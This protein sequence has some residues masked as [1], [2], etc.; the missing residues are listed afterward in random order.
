MDRDDELAVLAA[1]A[2]EV[3][4][5]VAR[6]VQPGALRGVTL[7]GVTAPPATSPSAGERRLW[8]F[9]DGLWRR[10]VAPTSSTSRWAPDLVPDHRGPRRPALRPGLAPVVG[11][12]Q[13][14]GPLLHPAR[15]PEFAD[16]FAGLAA[17]DVVANNADRK[18]GHVLYDGARCWAIDNGLCFHDAGQAAHRRL[19]VRR[20]S[21]SRPGP[22]RAPRRASREGDGARVARWLDPHEVAL[23]ARA[24]PGALCA[25]S[26]Y[27]T[28]DEDSRLAAVARGRWSERRAAPS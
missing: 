25:A 9:P 23:T 14:R 26:E 27:P 28:P 6:L 1:G 15:P 7:D 10:E 19:G 11:R 12:R 2:V 13:R 22:G 4:G 16:W 5:R 21:T 24:R 3:E 18:S 8:D 20:R 17:F